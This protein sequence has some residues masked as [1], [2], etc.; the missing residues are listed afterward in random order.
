MSIESEI[1]RTKINDTLKVFKR[2]ENATIPTRGSVLAAGYDLYSSEAAV[3]PAKGQNLVATDISI[4]VPVGT[5]GRVA[6]RSGLAVKHGIST[7]AGV[8]DADYRGEVKIVLFNHSD[9]DFK[10]EKGDRIAQLVLEKIVNADI[11]EIEESQLDDT[12]RGAGG[13]GSTGTN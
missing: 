10:I 4:I 5:Y 7:G 6:P 8:I 13:F 2:S 12:E 9:K 1:K 3:V 11:I